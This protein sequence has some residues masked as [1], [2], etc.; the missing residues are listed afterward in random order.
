MNS[1]ERSIPSATPA[2]NA[3]SPSVRDAL[4]KIPKNFYAQVLLLGFAQIA[5]IGK[6]FKKGFANTP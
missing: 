1:A 4:R 5:A 6:P 2:E 3:D